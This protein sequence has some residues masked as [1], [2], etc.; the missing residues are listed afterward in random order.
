MKR[1]TS[2]RIQKNKVTNKPSSLGDQKETSNSTSANT[3]GDRINSGE[4][5]D[6]DDEEGSEDPIHSPAAP[7]HLENETGRRGA[8]PESNQILDSELTLLNQKKDKMVEIMKGSSE[9]HALLTSA[10]KNPSGIDLQQIVNMLFTNKHFLN[11]LGDHL[12]KRASSAKLEKFLAKQVSQK[13]S[14]IS[15]DMQIEA[16]LN[17]IQ[18]RIKDRL[19]RLKNTECDFI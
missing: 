13:L 5:H 1:E 19:A 4:L 18:Q 17:S 3:N 10:D 2:L 12:V 8:K 6:S 15:T 16:S 7:F 14:E 9:I 11:L